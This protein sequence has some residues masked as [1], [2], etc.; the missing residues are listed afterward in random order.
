ME[1]NYKHSEI[2]GEII[3]AYYQV[4]NQLGCGF[5]E[6]VYERAMLLELPKYGLR[7]E[8]QKNI[9]VFYDGVEVGDYFADIFG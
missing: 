4:Y 3:N 9:K 2:T 8:S 6:K 1:D 7:C 5:L